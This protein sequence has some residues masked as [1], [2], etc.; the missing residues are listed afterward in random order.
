M[1][2]F[3]LTESKRPLDDAL[4]ARLADELPQPSRHSGRLRRWHVKVGSSGL[5]ARRE[6]DEPALRGLPIDKQDLSS[7]TQRGCC[8]NAQ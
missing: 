2:V 1:D 3:Y 6:F 7:L 4:K 5:R 8:V